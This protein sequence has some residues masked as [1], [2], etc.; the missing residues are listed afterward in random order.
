MRKRADLNGKWEAQYMIHNTEEESKGQHQHHNKDNTVKPRRVM[1]TFRLLALK[2]TISMTNVTVH[3]L[4]HVDD[5]IDV[6]D[7]PEAI[8][9]F[10]T[11]AE[12]RQ[13]PHLLA[14]VSADLANPLVLSASSKVQHD[15]W[16]HALRWVA[17]SATQRH[18]SGKGKRVRKRRSS[19]TEMALKS[20]LEEGLL[21]KKAVSTTIGLFRNWNLR[22]FKL[23]LNRSELEYF[24]VKQFDEWNCDPYLHTARSTTMD[25]HR[26]A[27]EDGINPIWFQKQCR[28]TFASVVLKKGGGSA[29]D[30]LGGEEDSASTRVDV[31]TTSDEIRRVWIQ[32]LDD[33]V[34]FNDGGGAGAVVDEHHVNQVLPTEIHRRIGSNPDLVTSARA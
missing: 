32:A 6:H 3:S 8:K 1:R 33:A 13:H 10:V 5:H 7:D 12:A 9:S 21:W 34:E 2:G 25:V 27:V 22:F 31:G 23:N 4:S 15:R 26:E 20:V 17:Q 30:E 11:E 16:L 18:K 24:D 28:F 29:V 14:I 19:M